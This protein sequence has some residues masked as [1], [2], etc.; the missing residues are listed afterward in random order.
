MTG[1]FGF[2]YLYSFIG[3]HT[4][5]FLFNERVNQTSN[6]SMVNTKGFFNLTNFISKE[7]IIIFTLLL[8]CSNCKNITELN[9]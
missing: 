3:M 8:E 5:P 4:R 9:N 1:I 6:T 7:K 2:I